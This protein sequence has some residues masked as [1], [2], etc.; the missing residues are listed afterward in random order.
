MVCT[1][2]TLLLTV[3]PGKYRLER[4]DSQRSLAEACKSHV[5]DIPIKFPEITH[6]KSLELIEYSL[7]NIHPPNVGEAVHYRYLF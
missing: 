4:F 3:L 6:T 1:L 7:K 2:S 5:G